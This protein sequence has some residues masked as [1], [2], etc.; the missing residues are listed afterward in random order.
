MIQIELD[1]NRMIADARKQLG[2]LQDKTPAVLRAAIN[3]T[4]RAVRKQLAADA[5]KRYQLADPKELNATK[6]MKLRSA[7]GSRASAR[8]ISTGAMKDLM[9]FLVSPTDV[10]NGKVPSE[11]SAKVLAASSLTPL[12][13]SPKPFVTTFA[14]GHTAIVVRV[15]GQRYSDNAAIKAREASQG[16]KANMD[17]LVKLLSPAVPHMIG[18]EEGQQQAQALV[19]EMLPQ[20][21]Q[22]EIEK[23]L[24]RAA[25]G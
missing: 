6:A 19:G 2:A 10:S 18:N 24:R 16:K 5:K 8:L 11:Y 9:D 15:P 17:K 12:G 7:T 14:S 4:A 3:S 21:L 13:K 20:L 1:T 23:T 25:G 22:K